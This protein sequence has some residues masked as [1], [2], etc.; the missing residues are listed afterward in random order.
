MN[1]TL[2]KGLNGPPGPPCFSTKSTPPARGAGRVLARP[3]RGESILSKRVGGI[4]GKGGALAP[5][6]GKAHFQAQFERRVRPLGVPG[7]PD[8]AHMVPQAVSGVFSLFCWGRK[9][10]GKLCAGGW[11]VSNKIETAISEFLFHMN[12]GRFEG[13]ISEGKG[14]CPHTLRLTMGQHGIFPMVMF[15]YL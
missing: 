9:D 1:M 7:T 5:L 12:W 2:P 15:F 11:W 6:P 3:G 14:V 13:G 8:S 10:G 4:R